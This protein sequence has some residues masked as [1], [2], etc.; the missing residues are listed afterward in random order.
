M[1]LS[2]TET[3]FDDVCVADLDNLR[4]L[5]KRKEVEVIG[6]NVRDFGKL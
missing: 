6:F 2:V 4:E 1:L 5:L 3:Y